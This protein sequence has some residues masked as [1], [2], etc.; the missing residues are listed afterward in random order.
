MYL[1]SPLELCRRRGCIVLLDQTQREC[2]LEHHCKE[3]REDCPL[4][5]HF[6]GLEFGVVASLEVEDGEQGPG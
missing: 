1:D 2:A 3:A 5:G 4:R 6:T